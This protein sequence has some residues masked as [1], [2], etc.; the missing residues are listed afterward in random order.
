MTIKNKTKDLIGHE[1]KA[2]IPADFYKKENNKYKNIKDD[3]NEKKKAIENAYKIKIVGIARAKKI[4]KQI[5]QI[6]PL[7]V[8]HQ[9]LLI[10]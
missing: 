1:F 7:L 6:L 8:L 10:R 3:E 4:A 9:N 2:L 5:K